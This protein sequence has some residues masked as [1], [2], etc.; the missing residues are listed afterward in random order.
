MKKEPRITQPTD[1]YVRCYPKIVE[2][3]NKQLEEQFWTS[4]EMKVELDRMHLLYKMA[5]HKVHAVKTVLLTFLKYE[6][7]VGDFWRVTVAE[8]FPRPE[9][10]LASAVIDAVEKGIHAEFYNQLN[11][12]LG[13]DTDEHYTAYLRHPVMKERMEWLGGILNGEDK[14]L[15]TII[16]SMTE[17]ALLFGLF[18]IL[19]SF[20]SNGNN[21]IP[22]IVRGT[23]QSAIDEDLHGQVI[24]EIINTYYNE[25]GITLQED[26]P[27]YKEVVKAIHHAKE[28]EFAMIDA[29]IPGDELNGT[30][31]QEFKEFSKY[32]LNVYCDRLGIPREFTIGECHVKDW[33]EKNTYAYKMIDFFSAGVGMEYESSWDKEGFKT[34][35]LKEVNEQH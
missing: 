22:V 1:S 30:P 3:A 8:T 25:L 7:M 26:T 2:L 9:V 27:R 35:W 17:T 31:K 15:S 16:F 6:L 10:K 34:A 20:Q 11:I 12:V 23:N 18:G 4:S 19:K 13:L 21:E 32:R 28:T 29:A 14:I 24:S 5:P 33:F